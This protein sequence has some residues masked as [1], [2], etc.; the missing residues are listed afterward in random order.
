MQREIPPQAVRVLDAALRCI[1]RVGLGKTTLD[2]VAREAGCAR[3]TVYR[4]FPGKQQLMGALV[5]RE[6]DAFRQK[7]LAAAHGAESLGEAVTT[8]ITTAAGALLGHPALTFV[9]AYEPETLLPYLAFERESAVLGAAAQLVAPAFAPF[10]PTD[11]AT[12]LAEWV[13]R[14]TLS[15]LC[16][17]SEHVDVND[18][19]QVRALVDDFVLP[20]YLRPAGA[21]E[22][23]TP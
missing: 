8:I 15:Y 9:A 17:P 16:C 19:R 20:G 1:G 13:A 5:E 3:A 23:I 22:G 2:D 11:R 18:A 7:L 10:L 12:R 6:V 21:L 14:I 4:Y